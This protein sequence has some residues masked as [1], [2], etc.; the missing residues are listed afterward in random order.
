[1]PLQGYKTN[2]ADK[3]IKEAAVLQWPYTQ[4]VVHADC[5]LDTATCAFGCMCHVSFHT[6]VLHCGSKVSNTYIRSMPPKHVQGGAP[7]PLLMQSLVL[8][9]VGYWKPHPILCYWV[10]GTLYQPGHEKEPEAI[11]CG[12]WLVSDIEITSIEGV[13]SNAGAGTATM[14]PA[15]W[16]SIRQH[17]PMY[18]IDCLT[19][20]K[21][22]N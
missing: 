15:F 1:M 2:R 3:A 11:A 22:I 13:R 6:V 18:D 12:T 16:G 17:T 19:P 8:G 4:A 21:I 7:P 14:D 10:V 5:I 20:C 9:T